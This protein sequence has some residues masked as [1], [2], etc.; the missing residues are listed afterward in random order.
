MIFLFFWRC[1]KIP[2]FSHFSTFFFSYMKLGTESEGLY[3]IQETA[4][5]RKS[6]FCHLQKRTFSLQEPFRS[7]IGLLEPQHLVGKLI[8]CI[9]QHWSKRGEKLAVGRIKFSLTVSGPVQ[10]L[11]RWQI[12][13]KYAPNISNLIYILIVTTFPCAC[14]ALGKNRLSIRANCELNYA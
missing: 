8:Q 2:L 9:I 7:F 6:L 13:Y 1:R 14:R 4:Q 10:S 12:T 11:Q 5:P 3:P